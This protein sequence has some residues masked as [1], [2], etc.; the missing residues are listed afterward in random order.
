M[1]LQYKSHSSLIYVLFNYIKDTASCLL[2]NT[3]S[4][5]ADISSSNYD[6]QTSFASH[7]LV[8][9]TFVHV[10]INYMAV[11]S[12]INSTFC[13]S[14]EDYIQYQKQIIFHFL[15]TASLNHKYEITAF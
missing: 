9:Q 3:T 15:K 12:S 10:H 7:I 5:F 1:A 8:C 6:A 14:I 13:S 11:G 2:G 4:K